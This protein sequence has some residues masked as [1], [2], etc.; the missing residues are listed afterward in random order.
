LDP[1][2]GSDQGPVKSFKEIKGLRPR[3]CHRH[4][5]RARIEFSP[6]ENRRFKVSEKRALT[7]PIKPPVDYEEAREILMS[8]ARNRRAPPSARVNAARAL[9]T[10]E[11]EAR[12]AA[13]SGDETAAEAARSAINNRASRILENLQRA[14]S[15]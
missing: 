13:A 8:I 14:R 9:L 11:R 12:V 10:C 4:H 2:T 5:T 1:A 7:K 3:W 15:N 6:Q